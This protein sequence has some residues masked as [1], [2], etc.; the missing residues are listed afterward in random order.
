MVT[1]RRPSTNRR[2]TTRR[3]ASTTRRRR[4]SGSSTSR[5][6]GRRTPR[7]STTL[8]SAFALALI[9]LFT[10]ASWPIRIALVL[11]AVV[12]FGAYLVIRAHQD[13]QGDGS[14]EVPDDG[15]D[16]GAQPASPPTVDKDAP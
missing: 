15:T 14:D 8:G 13:R 6:T 3:R 9:A 12:A 2:T 1:R 5:R 4:T 16:P 7:T 11:V 10:Q